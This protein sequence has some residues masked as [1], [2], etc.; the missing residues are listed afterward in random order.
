MAATLGFKKQDHE[1]NCDSQEVFNSDLATNK[2]WIVGSV[3]P[4]PGAEFV[5]I[6]PV[7]SVTS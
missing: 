3:D 6:I 7:D 1:T 5:V 2:G 4:D